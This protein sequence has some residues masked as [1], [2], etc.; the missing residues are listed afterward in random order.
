MPP[1]GQPGSLGEPS[2]AE[3]LMHAATA[4]GDSISPPA[5]A[6]AERQETVAQ[7]SQQLSPKWGAQLK[8]AGRQRSQASSQAG[9]GGGSIHKVSSIDGRDLTVEVIDRAPGMDSDGTRQTLRGAQASLQSHRASM[10]RARVGA[11]DSTLAAAVPPAITAEH[12]EAAGGVG[13][14][15]GNRSVD[16]AR[17]LEGR[18][19]DDARGM[20]AQQVSLMPL[21]ACASS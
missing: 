21:V 17:T 1:S 7:L 10:E 11:S 18:A 16:L 12:V 8:A 4:P 14:G 20:A 2:R 3:P 9:S 15:P 5:G 13:G 6:R 19:V